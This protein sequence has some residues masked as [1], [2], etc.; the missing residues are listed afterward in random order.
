MGVSEELTDLTGGA[1]IAG[2]TLQDFRNLVLTHEVPAE[3]IGPRKWRLRVSDVHEYLARQQRSE[4]TA[5][6]A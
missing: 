3:R 1:L 6:V 5:A 4:V 2:V